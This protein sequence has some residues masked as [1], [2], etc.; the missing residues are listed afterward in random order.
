M[1]DGKGRLAQDDDLP[2]E[3]EAPVIGHGRMFLWLANA[4]SAVGAVWIVALMLLIVLD[5]LG[6]SF[7]NSPITGVAEVSARSV[8]AIVF[9]QIAAAILAGRMTRADFFVR[10]VRSRAPIVL[11]AIEVAFA[12]VGASVFVL[13]VWSVWPDTVEAWRTSEYFGVRGVF[14]IPTLPF[15]VIIVLGGCFAIL[16]YLLLALEHVLSLR[17]GRK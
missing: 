1:N 3:S 16:A 14:T 13:I 17:Q 12:L 2:E 8:V 15:R 11:S 5:V 10:F 7:F 4:L 9:L 6:R